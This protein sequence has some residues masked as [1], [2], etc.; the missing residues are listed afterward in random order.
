MA[1]P[2][3]WVDNYLHLTVPTLDVSASNGSP[4]GLVTGPDVRVPITEYA[5]ASEAGYQAIRSLIR[6]ELESWVRS[7]GHHIGRLL[8]GDHNHIEILVSPPLQTTMGTIFRVLDGKGAPE[9]IRDVLRLASLWIAT[10]PAALQRQSVSDL[11]TFA[12]RYIGVDCNGYVGTYFQHNQRVHY[13]TAEFFIPAIPA[14]TETRHQLSEVQELDLIVSHGWGHVSLVATVF[15]RSDTEISCNE[16]QSRSTH[17]H[18][19]HT[20]RVTIRHGHNHFTINGQ[21]VTGIYGVRGL[22]QT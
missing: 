7:P 17:L 4:G 5:N 21:P 20:G 3:E 1:T 9:E 13:P 10:Q 19:V 18:G 11:Q 8:N 2:E 15:A 6:S 16:C 22:I 12:D 14:H